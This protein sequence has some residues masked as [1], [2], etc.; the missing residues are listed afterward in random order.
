MPHANFVHLNCHTQ[1]SLLDST[2]KVAELIKRSVEMKFPA[3]AMTD[4]GNLFG[5]IEFYSQAMKQGIKP[6]IGMHTYVAPGS[7]F[8]KQ[9]HGIKEA[10][11]HL[12]L[13]ARDETGYKN[14]LKLSSIGYLEG[15][16]YRPRVDKDVLAQYSEGLIGM[17]G[18][19]RGEIPHYVIHEQPDEAARAIGE[20]RDIFGPENFYLELMNHNLE[21]ELRLAAAYRKYAKEMGIGIVATNEVR[22]IHRQ[23]AHA[24]DMLLCIGIGATLEEPNRFR[25]PGDQYYLKSEQ[26][27]T[28][29]FQDFPDALCNTVEIANRCNLELDFKKIHLPR[30]QPPEGKTLDGYLRQLCFDLMV[31]RLG[32]E[33]PDLYSKRLDYELGVIHKMGYNGYFLIVWDFIHYAKEHGIPVGPGRGSAA[34]SLVA[35]ALGITDVDPIHHGLIFERFLNPERVSMPDIDIDFCYER[36]D[37]VIEYVKRRYGTDNVA[38]IITF[39]TMA[40]KAVV[41]DVG[42]VM[43]FSFQDTDKIAKLIPTELNITLSSAIQKEPKLK[44]LME[45]DSRVM[46][47][48]ETCKSLEGLSRH[49]STHAAGVVISDQPLTEYVPLFKANEQVSTQFTMKDLEKIGLLKMDFLGLKTLTMIQHT[50]KIVKRIRGIEVNLAELPMDDA[51]S[52]ELLSK[53][54]SAGVAFESSS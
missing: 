6:I 37:E 44:E 9:T 46:Q 54:T 33:L 49:A 17:S 52:Y 41:R 24:H 36:R 27:M 10:S 43:N 16:Y 31:K 40:A 28:Q 21:P 5:A 8:E 26:E 45:T 2:C 12:T 4:N 32:R 30:F 22:Y 18:G 1:F 11:H 34:G 38:Q 20:Y 48:M 29:I 51:A 35:Y 50:L 23:E 42:R 53:A 25:Y 39:G 15:F 19:L 13:L 3:L 47:L 7:R 14:L